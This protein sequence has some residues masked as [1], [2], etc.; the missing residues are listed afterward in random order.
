MKLYSNFE[1]SYLRL[2]T[3]SVIGLGPACWVFSLWTLCGDGV[4]V[5]LTFLLIPQPIS[6]LPINC[7]QGGQT[8]QVDWK[9]PGSENSIWRRT[10]VVKVASTRVLVPGIMM[11]TTTQRCSK[12]RVRKIF[13]RL[14]LQS[15]V[16]NHTM[17]LERM[18]SRRARPALAHYRHSAQL[19][20]GNS[21]ITCG[22]LLL[23][24]EREKMGCGV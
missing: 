8:M 14:F 16:E 3:W 5:S 21:L 20:I 10:M 17:A 9:L 6:R 13:S 12:E 15:A 24:K 22:D 18:D 11:P 1:I 23:C 4:S 19:A 2:E 7:T